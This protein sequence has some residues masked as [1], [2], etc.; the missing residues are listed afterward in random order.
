MGYVGESMDGLCVSIDDLCG[1]AEI[2]SSKG[3]MGRRRNYDDGTK[4]YKSKNLDTERK[5]RAK[6]SSRL[7][8]LRS[9][10]PIITN[11]CS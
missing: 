10:V 3:R 2:G 4:E 1:T 9:L 5:R 6:L 7:L 11:A 8:M